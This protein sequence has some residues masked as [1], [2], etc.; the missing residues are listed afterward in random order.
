MIES[1]ESAEKR[2]A[3][4]YGEVVGYAYNSDASDFVLPNTQRQVEC[5]H[6]A[7][8]KANLKIEDIKDRKSV[9]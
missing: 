5:M 3:K 8:S 7:M 9:V 1:L 6:K 4:I 2:N